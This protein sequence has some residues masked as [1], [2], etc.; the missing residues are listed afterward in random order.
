[1]ACQIRIKQNSTLM[2]SA[3]N[4]FKAK[5][6]RKKRFETTVKN[7]ELGFYLFWLRQLIW[8]LVLLSQAGEQTLHALYLNENQA[9]SAD[10]Q[11]HPP[12]WGRPSSGGDS[13]QPHP[14]APAPPL[15]SSAS[16]CTCS[17]PHLVSDR[18]K[19]QQCKFAKQEHHVIVYI[20]YF[21]IYYIYVTW[22]SALFLPKIKK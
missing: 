12:R 16:R 21:D 6:K 17:H 5:K 4:I 2:S 9:G 3:E 22:W 13:C 15:T 7:T 19:V 8:P 11:G 18:S 20:K 1:M 14:P 10:H